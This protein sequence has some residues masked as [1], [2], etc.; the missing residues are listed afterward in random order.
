LKDTSTAHPQGART[1]DA[2]L[3]AGLLDLLAHDERTT[4]LKLDI[5]VDGG[6]AH[7]EGTVGSEEERRLVRRLLRRHAGF[8]AVWDHLTMPGQHLEVMDIGCG[9]KKQRPWAVGVDRVPQPGVDV[10]AD[11][12]G[13][14][15]F[16]DG[17]FDH[18]FA[19]HVLEHIDDLLGL[20]AEL[21]RVLR[22]G[23]VLHVLAPLWRHTNAIA[24]P[25]HCR[26]VVPQTFKY[27][28]QPRASVPPWRPLIVSASTDT[29]YADLQP[30]KCGPS[31]T[32]EELALWFD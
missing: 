11:L 2:A 20:M 5:F 28:C 14:L 7:V 16:K 3:A 22:P 10:V 9:G 32:L 24:D 18:A 26:F 19:V 31:P 25:T 1:R 4:H 13:D 27:F 15:P 21:H 17:S 8:Y 30:V 12:E 6:V 29:V 23:G